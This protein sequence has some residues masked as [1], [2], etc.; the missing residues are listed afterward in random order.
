MISP[1]KYNTELKA[2]SGDSNEEL[3]YRLKDR[4]IWDVS[5]NNKMKYK[6]YPEEYWV[7]KNKLDAAH[8]R[9]VR[10]IAYVYDGVYE[11]EQID[12]EGMRA[13]VRA[14]YEEIVAMGYPLTDMK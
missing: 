14:I 2:Y 8:G 9:L 3:P 11:A 6:D 5:M 7:L 4:H 12:L 13:K 10:G 1:L